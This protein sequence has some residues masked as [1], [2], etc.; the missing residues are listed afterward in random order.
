[1]NTFTPTFIAIDLLNPNQTEFTWLDRCEKQ[2]ETIKK[3]ELPKTSSTSAVP[4]KTWDMNKILACPHMTK[5]NFRLMVTIVLIMSTMSG[6]VF[7]GIAKNSCG[8]YACRQAAE[9]R[10][11]DAPN[12]QAITTYGNGQYGYSQTYQPKHL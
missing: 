3:T 9:T 5:I 6:C 10:D 7:T 8:T 1:M 2:Y 12:G 4:Q 11:F